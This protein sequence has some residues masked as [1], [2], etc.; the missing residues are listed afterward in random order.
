MQK[1]IKKG[2]HRSFAH[3]HP[4][5][6]LGFSSYYWIFKVSAYARP[7]MATLTCG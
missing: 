4:P 1:K 7:L 2:F 3:F 5:N 6:P